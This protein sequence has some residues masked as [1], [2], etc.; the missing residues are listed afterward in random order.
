LRFGEYPLKDQTE[1]EMRTEKNEE[2]VRRYIEEIWNQRSVLTVNELVS[3]DFVGYGP[4]P[5]QM[6]GIEGVRT[7]TSFMNAM[8]EFTGDRTRYTIENLVSSGDEVAARITDQHMIKNTLQVFS[9]AEKRWVGERE[10]GITIEEEVR[11]SALALFIIHDGKIA[12]QY[13]KGV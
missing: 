10:S 9:S 2:L 13:L 5:V 1:D 8:S 7:F 12:T 3:E 4:G 11:G 6:Q